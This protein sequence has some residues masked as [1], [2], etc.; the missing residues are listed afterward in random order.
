MYWFVEA[1][2]L[3]C[4]LYYSA[5]DGI[6]FVIREQP[7]TPDITYCQR[8]RG[9]TLTSPDSW[10][11]NITWVI[12]FT[13]LSV[14]AVNEWYA[15]TE[16]PEWR[17]NCNTIVFFPPLDIIFILLET[18]RGVISCKG[19]VMGGLDAKQAVQIM[20]ML[21]PVS[22]RQSRPSPPHPCC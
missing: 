18:L 17:Q 6:M 4:H 8:I 2:M 9:L 12:S 11:L 20:R 5:Q 3:P 16:Q 7:H 19:L 1:A 22:A 14:I 15:H 21:F 10:Q 13:D